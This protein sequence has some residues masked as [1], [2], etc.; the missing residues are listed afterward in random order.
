LRSRSNSSLHFRDRKEKKEFPPVLGVREQM[1]KGPQCGKFTLIRVVVG[2]ATRKKDVSKKLLETRAEKQTGLPFLTAQKGVGGENRTLT[3]HR[4]PQE[5]GVCQ[6]TIG[7]GTKENL[8]SD[9][10]NLQLATEG[11]LGEKSGR[12]GGG[13]KNGRRM[14]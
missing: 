5:E 10:F 4:H 2:P 1:G 11:E 7:G 14:R 3:R 12:F 13:A 6:S 9:G 8:N